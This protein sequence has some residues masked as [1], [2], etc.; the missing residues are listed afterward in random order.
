MGAKA[1]LKVQ[2]WGNNLAVRLPAAVAREARLVEGQEVS[3]EVIDG[4]VV[5]RPLARPPQL[6]LAQ[7]LKVFD[8][9]RHGGE[10]MAAAARG[11]EFG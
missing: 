6:N 9:E 4:A 2:H 5:V 10:C 1:E 3:V 8:P 7:K 11:Q